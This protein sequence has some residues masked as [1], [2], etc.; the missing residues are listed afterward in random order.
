M[1]ADSAGWMGN[2]LGASPNL[3]AFAKTA[4]RFVNANVTVHI[5]QPGREAFMTGRVPH[6][7]GALGFNPIRKDVPIRATT[8][9]LPNSGGR[10]GADVEIA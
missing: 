9:R 6:R 2:K 10:D 8:S 5:C 1:N 4:H 3:D 7:S